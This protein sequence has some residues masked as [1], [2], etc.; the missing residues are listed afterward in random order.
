VQERAS[1]IGEE[2]LP[3]PSSELQRFEIVDQMRRFAAGQ[4][5]NILPYPRFDFGFDRVGVIALGSADSEDSVDLFLACAAPILVTIR[6]CW[7]CGWFPL[8]VTSG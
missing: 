2:R 1:T 4:V 3:Q 6:F 8:L 7:G 5:E